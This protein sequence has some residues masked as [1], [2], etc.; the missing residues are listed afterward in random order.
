MHSGHRCRPLQR[1][2]ALAATLLSVLCAPALAQTTAQAADQGKLEVAQALPPITVIGS[3]DDA[4]A[5]VG[6]GQY[7]DREDITRQGY[8]DIH[9]LLREIP[10]VYVREEDG[11]GLFPNISLRGVDPGRSAK[12]T[13]MEDGVL[14]APAPYTDPAAY[15]SPTA[16]RMHGIEV[17]KGSSQVRYGPH[18]TGGVINY[19]S[20]PIPDSRE[21]YIRSVFGSDNEFRN[22]V[23]VGETVESAGSGRFGYLVEIY[24][25]STDGFKE[26]DQPQT[27]VGPGAGDTGFSNIEPMIKLSWEPATALRQRFEFKYGYTDRDA[28]ETYLGLTTADFDANPYRRYAGSRFDNIATEHQRSYLRH[29]IAF[30]EAT[31][32]TTTAYYNEFHRN[33]FKIFGVNDGTANVSLG[34]ALADPA[35]SQALAVLRG[36]AAGNLR[37]RNNNREY[38]LRGVET[39]IAHAFATGSIEHRLHGGLRLHE[40]DIFRFQNDETFTQD[41]SGAITGHV[42]NPPGSQENREARTRALSAWL[43]D[44]IRIGRLT[45]RPGVRIEDLDWDVANFNSGSS[46]D[47][48]DSFY[49]AGIGVNWEQRP[50]FNWFGGLYQGISPPDPG[51]GTAAVPAKEE[52]SLSLEAGLRYSNGA[53]LSSEAVLFATRFDNLIVTGNLGASGTGDGGAV[54]EVDVY[55]LEYALRFDP[56]ASREGTLQLPMFLAVTYTSAEIANDSTG[57]GTGG[58]NVESIFSGGRKGAELPYIPEWQATAGIGLRAGIWALDLQAQYVDAVWAT[59]LNSREEVILAAA[60]TLAPDARGGRIDSIFLVDLTASAQVHPR[61]KLFANVFN[62]LDNEYIVSRLP[63]GPRPGA[64]LTA[65]VGIEARLF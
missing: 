45:L 12:L 38:S 41:D 30:S 14:T 29:S 39:Q 53:G 58:G 4:A 16:G 25:R 37:Y 51:S 10:G 13:L 17:L 55:G 2:Q 33:W 46:A 50:G 43:E 3:K 6:S 65:L 15:Y 44:E 40:D 32:L 59:A 19:L 61:V 57:S 20:T 34:A 24:Q 8:D 48:G 11:Y 62:L 1:H 52:R 23:W 26:L 49:T 56:L 21:G 63:E 47:G 36:E 18:S 35:Q 54:G 7:V 64:P 27:R 31:Q 9:R 5:L 22:Q 60:D 42:I 28:D